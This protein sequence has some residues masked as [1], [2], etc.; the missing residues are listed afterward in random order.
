MPMQY[1]KSI[2]D[3]L[4]ACNYVNYFGNFPNTNAVHLVPLKF[5]KN[6]TKVAIY[7]LGYIHPFRLSRLFKDKK[8]TYEEP[9]EDSYNIIIIHQNRYKGKTTGADYEECLHPQLLPEWIDLIIWCH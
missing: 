2:C 1:G 9:P 4:Q 5:E 8:I 6:G 7:G 3:L